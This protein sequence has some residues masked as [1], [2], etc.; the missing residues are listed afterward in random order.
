MYV[1]L[2]VYIT[3]ECRLTQ[4]RWVWED[5]GEGYTVIKIPKFEL[6]YQKQNH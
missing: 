2:Y 6:E 4:E 5:K 3:S 1:Y